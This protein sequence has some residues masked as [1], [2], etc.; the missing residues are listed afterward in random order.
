MGSLFRYILGPRIGICGGIS[1]SLGWD[2]AYQVKSITWDPRWTPTEKELWELLLKIPLSQGKK[3]GGRPPAETLGYVA[4]F[5]NWLLPWLLPST[6]A[7][8]H[9]TQHLYQCLLLIKR[10]RWRK[11]QF[12]FIAL[13]PSRQLGLL[14]GKHLFHS[15]FLSLNEE[16]SKQRGPVLLKAS[17]ICFLVGLLAICPWDTQDD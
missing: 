10:D 1:E 14:E 8:L 5:K 6:E 12:N 16:K 11:V 15:F 17:H 4:C 3:V 2:I 13:V 7:K 9:P